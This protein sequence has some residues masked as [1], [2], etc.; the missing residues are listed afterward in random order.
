MTSTL[1]SRIEGILETLLH[2]ERG[3]YTGSSTSQRLGRRSGRVRPS[4]QRSPS[5]GMSG[6]G[7]RPVAE[8]VAEIIDHLHPDD[9]A[10]LLERLEERRA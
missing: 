7:K 6:S 5:P 4:Q 10:L 3:A 9:Y 1:E 8:R 2:A